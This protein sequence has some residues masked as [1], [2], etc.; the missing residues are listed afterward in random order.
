M[1][2]IFLMKSWAL[3]HR[4]SKIMSNVDDKQQ[5]GKSLCYE[6]VLIS[7]KV[8]YSVMVLFLCSVNPSEIQA[9]P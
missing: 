4:D 6:Q 3:C 5:N 7:P 8:R 9:Q 2:E 1:T